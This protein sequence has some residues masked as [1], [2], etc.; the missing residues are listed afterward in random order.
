MSRGYSFQARFDEQP[1]AQDIDNVEWR[2]TLGGLERSIKLGAV[3]DTRGYSFY[4]EPSNLSDFREA[5]G[6]L[7]DYAYPFFYRDHE[8]NY[9]YARFDETPVDVFMTEETTT[10]RIRLKELL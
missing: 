7:N 2:E 9:K 10:K 8:N 1:D 3:R 4:H 6:Y 5:V